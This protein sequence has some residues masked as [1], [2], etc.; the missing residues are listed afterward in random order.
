[1]VKNSGDILIELSKNSN[2]KQVVYDNAVSV[3]QTNPYSLC[4]FAEYVPLADDADVMK[5]LE[6]GIIDFDDIVHIYEFMFLM[7]DLGIKNF[8]LPRF[9]KI[10]RDSKNPKLMVY[11]LCFVPGIDEASMLDSLYATKCR[12]YIEKLETEQDGIDVN[13]LPGYKQALNIAKKNLYFPDSLIIFGTRDIGKLI[14]RA[15]NYKDPYLINELAD[16]LEYLKVYLGLHY[17]LEPIE[18]AYLDLAKDEPLH[19]YEYSASVLSSDKD[20]F[21]YKVIQ[22]EMA[23]YMYYMYEY[24]EGV[25]KPLLADAINVTGSEKYISKIKKLG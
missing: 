3:T 11:S 17:N 15:I 4:D 8:N 14:P 21:T 20:A 13:K 19:L 10:I 22:K 7:V 24:V 12:K 18:K 1:M 25:N 16:Y 2:N 23:K 5:V 9:E 6:D